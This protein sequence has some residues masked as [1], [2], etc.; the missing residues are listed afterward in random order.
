MRAQTKKGHYFANG[1]KNGFVVYVWRE[2]K[3]NKGYILQNN[4]VYQNLF[5]EFVLEQ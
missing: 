1:K 5:P 2:R 4:C 3:I